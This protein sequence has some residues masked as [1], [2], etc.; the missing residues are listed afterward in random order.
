MIPTIITALK[1]AVTDFVTIEHAFSMEPVDDLEAKAPAAYLYQGEGKGMD[2][3][4]DSCVIKREQR[5]VVVLIV[6]KWTDLETLR[7]QTKAVIRGYQYKPE[8][9]PLIL[10][11]SQTVKIR[12]EYIWRKDIYTTIDYS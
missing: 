10:A 6:C 2:D 8:Q 1:A 3:Y 4:A 11:S 9:T 7:D 12:G 5:S